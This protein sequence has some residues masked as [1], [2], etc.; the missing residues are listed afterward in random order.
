MAFEP[1]D[2]KY[3]WR[4][5]ESDILRRRIQADLARLRAIAPEVAEFNL[6]YMTRM[7]F[8]G[9]IRIPKVNRDAG[10]GQPCFCKTVKGVRKPHWDCP[11]H[12]RR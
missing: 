7:L 3:N 6:R 10:I 4:S 11:T 9:T 1:T 2:P 5:N 12:E 8:G